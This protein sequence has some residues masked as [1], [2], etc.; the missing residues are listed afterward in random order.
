MFTIDIL[1]SSHTKKEACH[2]DKHKTYWTI[3]NVTTL[4]ISFTSGGKILF[5]FESYTN[6]LLTQAPCQCYKCQECQ[7]C[8]KDHTVFLFS[9]HHQSL[10]T[11]IL[12]IYF[13]GFNLSND[14]RIQPCHKPCSKKWRPRCTKTSSSEMEN[15]QVLYGWHGES[16]RKSRPVRVC[17]S[18]IFDL[19]YSNTAS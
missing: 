14:L 1:D 11:W 3:Y 12:W 17:S 5:F 19:K 9:G 7:K 16:I 8:F 18:F 13:M 4:S 10:K 2:G 6:V 15:T